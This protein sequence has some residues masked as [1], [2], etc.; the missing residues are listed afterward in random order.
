MDRFE[1]PSVDLYRALLKSGWNANTVGEDRQ[2]A[3]TAAVAYRDLQS[4]Q[5]LLQN[6][7]AVT[8]TAI[9]YATMHDD[10]GLFHLPLSVSVIN[11]ENQR[12]SNA[13]I[14]AARSKNTDLLRY[15]LDSGVSPNQYDTNSGLTPL[16]NATENN[17]LANAA[18]LLEHGARPNVGDTYG[19]RPLW[20]AA[21]A[22]NTGFIQLLVQ[23]GAN[24]NATDNYSQTAL[25]SAT[26]GCSYW[27]I[28]ALLKASADP[29]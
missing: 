3:L 8:D 7:S 13:V 28:E 5:F 25:M 2:N 10:F 17:Q 20:Y 21:N 6:G 11:D 24:V 12:A 27:D 1:K 29:P 14:G 26:S 18:L 23:H 4:V 9:S 19:R 16:L 22:S 15:L